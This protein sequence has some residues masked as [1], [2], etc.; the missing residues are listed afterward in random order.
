MKKFMKH[1]GGIIF[2]FSSTSQNSGRADSQQI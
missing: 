1:F 2:F